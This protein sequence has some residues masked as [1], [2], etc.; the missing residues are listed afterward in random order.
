[1]EIVGIVGI[2]GIVENRGESWRIVEKR[3]DRRNRRKGVAEGWREV[4]IKSFEA[5]SKTLIVKKD[6]HFNFTRH[7]VVGLQ[8]EACHVRPL[9]ASAPLGRVFMSGIRASGS[10]GWNSY[11]GNEWLHSGLRT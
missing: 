3:G 4:A 9:R 2:E 7:E 8:G 10:T 11:T 5:E 1:M 6:G